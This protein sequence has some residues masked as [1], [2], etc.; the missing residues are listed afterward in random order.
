MHVSEARWVNL[1]YHHDFRPTTTRILSPTNQ[2]LF[3]GNCTV[4]SDKKLLYQHHHLFSIATLKYLFVCDKKYT[5][6]HYRAVTGWRW[7]SLRV[8]VGSL[9]LSIRRNTRT[10][11]REYLTYR[12]RWVNREKCYTWCAFYKINDIPRNGTFWGNCMFL[13]FEA[14]AKAQIWSQ[15]YFSRRFME[16]VELSIGPHFFVETFGSLGIFMD[17]SMISVLESYSQIEWIALPVCLSVFMVWSSTG[18]GS[19]NVRAKRRLPL[20][21]WSTRDPLVVLDSGSAL[22][23]LSSILPIPLP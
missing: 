19:Y 22:V 8:A 14:V 4:S 23:K 12:I 10:N 2:P 20:S 9:W 5:T 1:S 17:I 7:T 16:I 3:I 15:F 21:S 13:V 18:S 11:V 6:L